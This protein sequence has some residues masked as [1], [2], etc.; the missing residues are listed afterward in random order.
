MESEPQPQHYN[1]TQKRRA[2]TVRKIH[3]ILDHPSDA[4]LVVIF[5][6]IHCC[7]YTSRDV[8]IMRKIYGEYELHQRKV[9]QTIH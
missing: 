3:E 9:C 7:P 4:V 1:A 2:E 6:T 8:R 5:D